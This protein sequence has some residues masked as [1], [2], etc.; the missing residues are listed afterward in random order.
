MSKVKL[1]ITGGRGCKILWQLCAKWRKKGLSH[2]AESVIFKWWAIRDSNPRP[3]VPEK[4]KKCGKYNKL[5]F[6]KL[7]IDAKCDIK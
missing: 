6:Q 1:I 4:F 2:L 5:N 3:L 7:Q